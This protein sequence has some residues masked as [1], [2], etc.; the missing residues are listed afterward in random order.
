M[1]LRRQLEHWFESHHVRPRVVAEVEDTALLTDLRAQGLGFIPI[2]SSVLD[3][4]APTLPL[5]DNRNRQGSEN[6]SI[7]DYCPTPTS[8]PR[9]GS[10]DSAA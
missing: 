1:T 7:R 9:R 2:Y 6:G 4:I 10:D 5:S 8:A 3:E